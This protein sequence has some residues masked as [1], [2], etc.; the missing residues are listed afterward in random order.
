MVRSADAFD[1]AA[2]GTLRIVFGWQ[3]AGLRG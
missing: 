1:D 3:D 2:V